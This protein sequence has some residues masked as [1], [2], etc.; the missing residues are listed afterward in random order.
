MRIAAFSDIHGHLAA[1]DAVLADIKR[2]NVDHLVCLGDLVALRPHPGQVL[3]RIRTLG[4]PVVQGNTD[5]WYKEPLPAGWRP[6]R[7]RT[8]M[9]RIGPILTGLIKQVTIRENPSHPSNPCPINEHQAMILYCYL[10][11]KEQLTPEQHA[12]LLSLPF[13]QRSGLGLA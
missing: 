1:L 12:R 7:N 13:Q 2:H 6:A 8:R 10:W 9:A 3:E 5:T 4:C 11:L